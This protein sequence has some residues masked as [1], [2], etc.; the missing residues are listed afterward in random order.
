L[1]LNCLLCGYVEFTSF[2]CFSC[3]VSLRFFAAAFR[4]RVS[5]AFFAASLRFFAAMFVFFVAAAFLPAAR[6]LVLAAAFLPVAR[7]FLVAAA[8]F[9]AALR[10]VAFFML[11][12]YIREVLARGRFMT[13]FMTDGRPGCRPCYLLARA[14]GVGFL[15][16]W[17][18]RVYNI[19]GG[20]YESKSIFARGRSGLRA[21]RSR[22]CAPNRV[23]HVPCDSR[24]FRPDVGKLDRRSYHGLSWL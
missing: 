7:C 22:P 21:D 13:R 10:F 9:P 11:R 14:A 1:G 15:E 24:L 23:R 12:K 20:R 8:F 3:T 16:S 18:L 17:Q 6:C 19:G 5:L 4:L 2:I